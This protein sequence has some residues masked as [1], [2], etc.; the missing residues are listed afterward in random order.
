MAWSRTASQD[1]GSW[2]LSLRDRLRV[3]QPLAAVASLVACAT[4]FI[5]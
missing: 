1:S 2:D 4:L 5:G 3:I